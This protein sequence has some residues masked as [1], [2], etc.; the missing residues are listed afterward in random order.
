[1]WGPRDV[2]SPGENPGVIPFGI[3]QRPPSLVAH[4]SE[5]LSQKSLVLLLDFYSSLFTSWGTGWYLQ[6]YFWSL[7]A[8]C[9]LSTPMRVQTGASYGG[10]VKF[11]CFGPFLV[12]WNW[13]RVLFP[14]LLFLCSSFPALNFRTRGC[15]SCPP[16]WFLVQPFSYLGFTL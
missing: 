14:L 3:P 1:M 11:Q 6:G 13:V 12:V 8:H 16:R 4:L 15:V 9:V 10:V 5:F 2:T 7:W